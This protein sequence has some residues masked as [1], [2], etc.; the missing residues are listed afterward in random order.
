ML[1]ISNK[2]IRIIFPNIGIYRY[3]TIQIIRILTLVTVVILTEAMLG[4]TV[5][6]TSMMQQAYSDKEES[7]I[8]GEIEI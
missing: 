2:R 6:V 3:I 4:A 8:E 5:G 1:H 7:P